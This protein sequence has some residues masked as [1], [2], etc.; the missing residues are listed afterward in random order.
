MCLNLCFQPKAPVLAWSM[1]H[2][3]SSGMGHRKLQRLLPAALGSSLL[4][5]ELHLQLLAFSTSLPS[6]AL[7][8]PFSS[9]ISQ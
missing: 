3:T 5:H 9:S 2:G 4:I 6:P 7:M 1:A 8:Y